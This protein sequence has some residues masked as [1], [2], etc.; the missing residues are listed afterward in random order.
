MAILT[1]AH[2]ELFRRNPDTQFETLDAMIADCRQTHES[3]QDQWV[4]HEQIVVTS[5]M[6]VVL[7]GQPDYRF[8]DWSFSQLCRMAG[9]SRDTINR[10]TH[11]T[12]SRALQET[13]PTSEKPFQVLTSGSDIRSIH[14][15]AYTRLWNDELLHAVTEAAPGFAAPQKAMNEATGLYCGEQD[16]FAFLIDPTGWIEINDQA[17]APGFF[18][19]NSEVGRRSVGIQTFWFQRVCQNHI[20]WDAVE[21]VET[22]RRHT[23]GVRGFLDVTRTT[24]AQLVSRRDER[25]DRFASVLGRAMRESLGDDADSVMKQLQKHGVSKELGAKAIEMAEHSGGFTIFS[26]VDALTQLSQRVKY[27]GDRTAVDAKVSSLL[28]LVA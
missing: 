26:L 20:V 15:V 5:D 17:F 28:S 3:S 6:T 8:N 12:A 21:V 1:R 7:D 14:G 18:V 22:T 24:V 13:L 2:E 25:R 11:K 16:M 10:L 19:W 27:I 4:P 23:A 9:V